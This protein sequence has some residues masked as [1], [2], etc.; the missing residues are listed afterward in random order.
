MTSQPNPAPVDV[1]ELRDVL[2]ADTPIGPR[3]PDKI[4]ARLRLLTRGSVIAERSAQSA[5][6]AAAHWRRA[7]NYCRRRSADP[8][9][10]AF[11]LYG[12]G[13]T[14]HTKSSVSRARLTRAMLRALY[15]EAQL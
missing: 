8:V 4:E 14:C 12:T 5:R 3:A 13:K 11:A 15:A 6:R 9:A 10:G 2:S 7:W 1:G